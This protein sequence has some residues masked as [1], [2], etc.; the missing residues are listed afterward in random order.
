MEILLT[1]CLISTKR[2]RLSGVR[3]YSGRNLQND[4]AFRLAQTDRER[5]RGGKKIICFEKC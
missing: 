2:S 1:F 4:A 5:E 3:S